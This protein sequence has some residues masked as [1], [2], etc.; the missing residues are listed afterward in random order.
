MS[1]PSRTDRILA[2]I[3]AELDARRAEIDSAHVST[4]SV[5]VNLDRITREPESVLCQVATRREASRDG[6]IISATA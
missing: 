5:T 1:A 4:V 2:E 6:R 3:A